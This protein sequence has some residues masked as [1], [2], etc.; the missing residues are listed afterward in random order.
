MLIGV[1]FL[2]TQILAS[3]YIPSESME[4]TLMVSDR[5]IGNRLAYKFGKEPERFDIIIFNAPDDGELYIKRIIGLPGEKVTISDGSVLINNKIIDDSFI[6]EPMED[7]ED[8]EFHVPEGHYFVLGDNRNDSYDSRYWDD[9]YVS[10]NSI[11]AK[12]VFKYWKGFE[13]L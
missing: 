9:P 13:I 1:I 6:M 12:A 4:N 8:M 5:I 11:V 2:Y 10:Q 3:A 7:N